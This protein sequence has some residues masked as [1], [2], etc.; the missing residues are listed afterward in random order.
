MKSGAMYLGCTPT[1]CP[2]RGLRMI[3]CLIFGGADGILQPSLN[4]SN[5]PI[6]ESRSRVDTVFGADGLVL[7]AHNENHDESRNFGN[8]CHGHVLWSTTCNIWAPT[9]V[10]VRIAVY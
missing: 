6:F 7:S 2:K 1:H 8:P 3:H 10:G 5:D 4:R 9:C